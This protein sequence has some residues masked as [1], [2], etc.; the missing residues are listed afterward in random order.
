[1]DT[2]K[3]DITALQAELKA[4]KVHID[5]RH[6]EGANMAS[7]QK[8]AATLEGKNDPKAPSARAEADRIEESYN[9][10]HEESLSELK[11]WKDNAGS[12]Y[13]G[14]FDSVEEVVQY[15]FQH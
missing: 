5:E 6:K 15:L 12:R 8:K 4:M 10:K 1:V 13:S 9:N 11:A 2:A 3:Q 7:A 14:L